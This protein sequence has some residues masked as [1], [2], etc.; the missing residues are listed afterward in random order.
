[1][2]I[3][4]EY[5]VHARER[6]RI[7]HWNWKLSF[8]P[9]ILRYSPEKLTFQIPL[10]SELGDGVVRGLKILAVCCRVCCNV[11]M[12]VVQCCSLCCSLCCRLC[13][14]LWLST[15]QQ[16]VWHNKLFRTIV[17]LCWWY[18]KWVS[19]VT[20]EWVLSHMNESWHTWMRHI[21]CE[22]AFP[23]NCTTTTLLVICHPNRVNRSKRPKPGNER[24][25]LPLNNFQKRFSLITFRDALPLLI[26][27]SNKSY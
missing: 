20:Y 23:Y 19:D 7:S 11:S 2:D 8:V 22:W 9:R 24:L 1:M 13:C 27:F 26:T 18:H 15:L 6:R 4:I 16:T 17:Q 3:Y 10:N 21:T 12:C 14:S 25:R 5:R